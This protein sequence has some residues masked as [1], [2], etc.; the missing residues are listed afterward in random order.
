MGELVVSSDAA[1]ESGMSMPDWLQ[2]K[3]KEL[4]TR[5][6]SKATIKSFLKRLE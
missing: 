4:S 2:V 3:I 5:D 1:S 6:T